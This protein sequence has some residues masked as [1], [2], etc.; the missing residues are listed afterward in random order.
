VWVFFLVLGLLV[1]VF[2]LSSDWYLLSFRSSSGGV[3]LTGFFAAIY[4]GP[5]KCPTTVRILDIFKLCMNSNSMK[6]R[7]QTETQGHRKKILFI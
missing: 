6:K 1:L 5:F 7:R 4:L 3:A 2:L